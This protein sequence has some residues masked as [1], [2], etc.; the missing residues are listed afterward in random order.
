MLQVIFQKENLIFLKK[1]SEFM[2]NV[3]LTASD[4]TCHLSQ[5]GYAHM[6]IDAMGL[7][8]AVMS[9]KM[10]PYQSSLLIDLLISN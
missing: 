7:Q 8:D 3:V 4:V 5:E 1:N 9:S 10:T 2:P 6:L